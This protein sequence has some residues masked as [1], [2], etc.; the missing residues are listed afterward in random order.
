[1]KFIIAGDT[2]H[3]YSKAESSPASLQHDFGIAAGHRRGRPR[4]FAALTCLGLER[5]GGARPIASNP[6]S[7]AT[8]LT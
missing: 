7:M 8:L 3:Q 1:M 5:C 4:H 6:R 2:L